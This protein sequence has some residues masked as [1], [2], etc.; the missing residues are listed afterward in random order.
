MPE[1][2]NRVLTDHLAD[3]LFTTER[4]AE[5]NLVAEGI[6]PSRI[7]FVGNVMIDTLSVTGGARSTGPC[8]PSLAWRQAIR[9]LHDSPAEQRRSRRC[10]PNTVEALREVAARIDHGRAAASAHERDASRSSACS[11]RSS[12]Q[13]ADRHQPQGYLDFLASDES[14]PAGVHRFG[15]HTGRDDGARAFRA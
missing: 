9:A 6:P 14:R 7:H 11:T 4:T 10:G 12:D 3:W 8:S 1:E 2:I 15:R 13:R 5:E